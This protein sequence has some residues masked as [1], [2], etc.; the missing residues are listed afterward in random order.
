MYCELLYPLLQPFWP[1]GSGIARGFLGVYDTAW[2]L[3]NWCQTPP[4]S[5]VELLSQREKVYQ[6]LPQTTPDSLRAAPSKYT[7]D[8]MTRSVRA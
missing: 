4:G 1:T 3:R 2:L 5:E 6:F 8:P 7:I